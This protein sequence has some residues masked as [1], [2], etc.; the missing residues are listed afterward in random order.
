MARATNKVLVCL[1]LALYVLA[2]SVAPLF[3]D[4]AAH[5]CVSC[6]EHGATDRHDAG[7][8]ACTNHGHHEHDAEPCESTPS[9]VP[10]DDS[11]RHD[12]CSVC[13]FLAQPVVAVTLSTAEQIAELIEPVVAALEQFSG[14]AGIRSPFSGSAALRLTHGRFVSVC[15]SRAPS[16]ACKCA[17]FTEAVGRAA[18]RAAV[19]FHVLALYLA[20]KVPSVRGPYRARSHEHVAKSSRVHPR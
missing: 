14:L 7:E 19:D 17:V 3:H 8:H 10:G 5:G 18:R 1:A 12:Q 6:A 13:R 2:G 4:L 20:R 16:R 15:A 11:K 9:R